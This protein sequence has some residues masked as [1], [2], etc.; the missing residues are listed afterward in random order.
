MVP[1]KDS[2][3]KENEAVYLMRGETIKGGRCTLCRWHAQALGNGNA[4]NLYITAMI[5]T[6]PRPLWPPVTW[7]EDGFVT[8]V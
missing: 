5:P 7:F 3:G 6:G 8:K 4:M 2:K 1:D